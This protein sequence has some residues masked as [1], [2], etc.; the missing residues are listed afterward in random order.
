L[1]L[2]MSVM[3]EY[4]SLLSCNP[5]SSVVMWIWFFWWGFQWVNYMCYWLILESRIQGIQWGFFESLG[6]LEKWLKV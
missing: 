1:F 5:N 6:A 3:L 4:I 2:P